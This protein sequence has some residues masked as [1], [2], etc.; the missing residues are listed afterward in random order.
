MRL[1]GPIFAKYT[2]PQEWAAAVKAAGYRSVV[3]PV[4]N[5][6]DDALIEAYRLAAERH[7]IVIAEV[8]AWSNPISPNDDVREAALDHCKKQLNLAEKIGARICV[9]I[10][11]SRGEQW[12]GPHPDNVSGETFELIVDTVRSIIDDVKPKRAFYT[13]ESMPWALPDSPDAYLELIKAIDRPQFA[14]HLDPVNLVNSPRRYYDNAS[15][16]RECFAKLGPYIKSCHAKDIHLSGKLTVHLS[17]VIPGTG[18]L[19]YRV[20]L[21]ELNKLDADTPI[22]LEHLSSEDEYNQAA[23]FIRKTAAD[24][25]I[26]L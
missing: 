21:S 10:A 8:G 19:D 20:F 18:S 2:D 14:V 1:G 26:A 12:D 6:A 25:N 17:E 23:A 13:L 9:N 16:I 22:L 7:D 3:C 11:G 24:M 15:L 5:N 4:S